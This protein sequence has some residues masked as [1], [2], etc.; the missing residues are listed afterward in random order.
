MS[1]MTTPML[2][3]AKAARAGGNS[4]R[5]YAEVETEYCATTGHLPGVQ[6][7]VH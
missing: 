4:R 1:N 5:K 3:R 6:D 7:V 2:M